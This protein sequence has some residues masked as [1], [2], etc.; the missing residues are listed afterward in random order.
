MLDLPGWILIVPILAL[1]I[2]VHEL[3]HFVSA[4]MF[5]IKVTEFG[6][7]FPP[8]I[9]GIPYRGTVYSINL[10]PLGGF[11]RMVG[12]EDPSDPESFARKSVPKRLFV[13]AAGSL[14]N[15]VLPVV[16]FTILL[17]IP[18]ETL[19][20]GAVVVSAVAPGS[21]AKDAELRAGDVILAVDGEP[22]IS[23]GE[24]V[25]IVRGKKDQPI[26]ISLRRSNRVMGLSQSP[27]LTT[28]DIAV[29]VP[30]SSPPKL[31]V[32]Q[33][34]TDP[35]I[36]V[37]LLDARKYNPNLKIGDTLTQGSIGVMIGLANPKFTKA[38]QPIWT[39]VPSAIKQIWS[40]ISMTWN[41]IK[42]GVSTRTNPGIAGPVGIAHATGEVVEQLGI[43]WILQIAAV[44]SVS[45]GVVN[46]L[47]IPALDGGRFMFVVVEW[48]R[49]GKK[50]SPKREG[51][52]HLVGFV[53]LIGLILVITY[54]DVV[55]IM[56]GES[57]IR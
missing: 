39:A 22:V 16:I 42:E 35:E 28:F 19:V 52:V 9:L 47:P 55:K 51:L 23:P 7:G 26:E 13:L 4:K 33:E 3:G 29:V 27:E 25:D 46:M 32:V 50:I 49:R 21:P 34:V 57:F 56:N 24:L 8:R 48:I 53:V 11:V 43:S 54:F 14:M 15:F 41:G 12:E 10:I 37:G 36:E 2:F 6:F 18:H 17:M 44:L 38:S 45:L 5:G 40:I 20:G 1:L 30:R 31:K